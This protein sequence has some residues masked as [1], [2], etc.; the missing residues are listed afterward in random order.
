MDNRHEDPRP[1]PTLFP[2]RASGPNR[3][4]LSSRS[5]ALGTNHSVGHGNGYLRV[6]AMVSLPNLRAP[7]RSFPQRPSD[8]SPLFDN[9]LLRD[10]W[11][12]ES[13]GTWHDY[14]TADPP[15]TWSRQQPGGPLQLVR[16]VR[17][18][19]RLR[20]GVN[21]TYDETFS[22][23]GHDRTTELPLPE[24]EWA[25]WDSQGRLVLA[26]AGQ[27]L[28]ATIAE[29]DGVSERVLADFNSATPS[30]AATPIWAKTW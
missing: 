2:L 21:R 25:D 10:G 27:I 22:V 1:I 12:Q 5:H 15:E 13:Q 17:G 18:H 29:G 9:R 4:H 7:M 8:G 3:R 23:R 19:F 24:V 14:K 6:R 11:V 26:R 20:G 16:R 28:A 30:R